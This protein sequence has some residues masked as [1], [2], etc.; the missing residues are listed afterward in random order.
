MTKTAN[1]GKA[2]DVTMGLADMER[3]AW[4]RVKGVFREQPVVATVDWPQ[5]FVV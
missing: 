1:R 2:L 4:S 5:M 3:G